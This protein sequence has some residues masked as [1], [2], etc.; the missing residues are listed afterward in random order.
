MLDGSL[1]SGLDAA[2]LA[3]AEQA[4][5]VPVFEIGCGEWQAPTRAP[6]GAELGL[7]VLEGQLLREL[8]VGTARSLE[9]LSRGDLLRPWQE[10]ASSFCSAGWRVL[11]PAS[12]AVLDDQAVRALA[13]WPTIVVALVERSLRRSRVVALE[14][15]VSNLVGVDR[16]VLTL[17]WLLAERWG[18]RDDGGV[19]VT[20]KLTHQLLAEMVGARR[21][22]VS[23][24]I[25][26]LVEAGSIE[27]RADG[28]WMLHGDP[29]HDPEQAGEQA[30]TPVLATR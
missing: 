9:L 14:A 7:L 3:R 21:P 6:R 20:I 24:A 1:G 4:V 30:G 8:S 18:R 19:V 22:S 16:R 13:E 2:E 25:G 27:C 5:K 29:P 15:A 23:Q 26:Q 12:V 10:D 28:C 11:E 17:L